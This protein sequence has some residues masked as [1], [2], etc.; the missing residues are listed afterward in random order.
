MKKQTSEA[1]DTVIK[2]NMEGLQHLVVACN[3]IS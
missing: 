2:P 3:L 1:T